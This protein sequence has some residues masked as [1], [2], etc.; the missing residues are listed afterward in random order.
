M[1][2]ARR[3]RILIVTR[4]LPPLM[5]G[6]EWLNWHLAQE[7]SQ[8][9]DVRVIGP[10]GAAAL[11]PLGVLIDEVPL[12]PLWRFLAEAQ[13]KALRVAR[14]WRPDFVLAGSGLTAPMAWFASKWSGARS[15]VYVHGLDMAVKQIV[16]KNVWFPAIRRMNSVIANSNATRRLAIDAGVPG[17]RIK[18][19]HPGVELPENEPDASAIA[20]FRKRLQLG[21]RPLLL[22]VGRLSTRKGMREF[23]SDVLPAV[24]AQHPE[25]MLLIVGDAPTQALHAKSQSIESI[26]LAAE[27]KGVGANIRF[28]GVIVDRNELATVYQAADIHVFPVREIPG[29]PEGFGM[30][31]IEAAANG[32]PTVAYATGGIV[33]AVKDGE[34]GRLI[35]SG[36]ADAMTAAILETLRDRE[37]LRPSCMEFATSFGWESFGNQVVKVLDPS[38]MMFNPH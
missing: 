37:S 38:G 18:I 33:D 36:D 24:V 25:V 32:L 17:D 26:Q 9:A 13:L 20:D 29:D 7:L 12:V 3:P 35:A 5:G 27:T 14:Q 11:A 10:T 23:V 1:S 31:A 16:Y 22:S 15:A 6:M 2:D 8:R 21:G 28:L 34:S 19:V 30:V 4:N